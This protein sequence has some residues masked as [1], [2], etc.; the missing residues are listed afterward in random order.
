MVSRIFTQE[1]FEGVQRNRNSKDSS[2]LLPYEYKL[3]RK[4][5][6]HDPI[7]RRFGAGIGWCSMSNHHKLHTG[8]TQVSHLILKVLQGTQVDELKKAWERFS[9]SRRGADL[10]FAQFPNSYTNEG[11]EDHLHILAW[12]WNLSLTSR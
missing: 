8:I 9:L 12:T 3:H 4:K 7:L 6:Q 1:D 10:Q 5:Y 11:T 2:I